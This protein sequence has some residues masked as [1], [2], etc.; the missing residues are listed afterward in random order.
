MHNNV[1]YF[2]IS[3]LNC[4]NDHNELCMVVQICLERPHLNQMVC[5]IIF[6]PIRAKDKLVTS[7]NGDLTTCNIYGLLSIYGPK[8][9]IQWYLSKLSEPENSEWNSSYCD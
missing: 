8:L 2:T 5:S 3:K 7:Q 6:D 9:V 4:L 1:L